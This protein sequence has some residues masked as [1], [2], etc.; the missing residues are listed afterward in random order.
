M[1]IIEMHSL[2]LF[3]QDKYLNFRAKND[4]CKITYKLLIEF[5]KMKGDLN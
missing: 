4:F 1:A 3:S 5:L 2:L